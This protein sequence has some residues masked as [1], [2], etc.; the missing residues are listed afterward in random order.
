MLTF[1]DLPKTNELIQAITN[2][3]NKLS[4]EKQIPS[5]VHTKFKDDLI[6]NALNIIFIEPNMVY[7]GIGRSYEDTL[8]TPN[9]DNVVLNGRHI[10][11]FLNDR[12]TDPIHKLYWCSGSMLLSVLCKNTLIIAVSLEQISKDNITSFEDILFYVLSK[13]ILTDTEKIQAFSK[14]VFSTINVNIK[15]CDYII[16][17]NTQDISTYITSITR[18]KE[19]MILN[20]KKKEYLQAILNEGS[21]NIKSEIE[22]LK[23]LATVTNITM[24]PSNLN[25][26]TTSLKLMRIYHTHTTTKPK[27]VYEV[28]NFNLDIGAYTID[29]MP[30]SDQTLLIN[31]EF[32]HSPVH[33]H[34]N[35]PSNICF[36]N[37]LLLP[38]LLSS[39]K[40]AKLVNYL[41][42]TYLTTVVQDSVYCTLPWFIIDRLHRLSPNCKIEYI[43]EQLKALVDLYEFLGFPNILR[44]KETRERWD[45]SEDRYKELRTKIKETD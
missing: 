28:Q 25:I 11:I 41:T 33:P 18:L 6:P 42:G 10:R 3:Y 1:H 40:Y 22:E 7:P 31:N 29:L 43:K 45:I 5:I 16:K 32:N 26:K 37:T 30:N 34:I 44:N 14:N 12:I 35:A 23:K 13:N 39:C 27:G 8:S 17:Q 24:T 36:G 20:N 15:D 2:A 19:G 9:L 38:D 4:P 21:V